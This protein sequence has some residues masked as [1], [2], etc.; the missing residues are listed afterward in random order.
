M[1]THSLKTNTEHAPRASLRRTLLAAAMLASSTALI[2]AIATTA[3]CAANLCERK[4]TFFERRC[5]GTDLTYSPD[6]LCE[7]NLENCNEGQLRAFEG[8]VRCLEAA[9][10]CS[11]EIVSQC[12]AQHAPG[13]NLQCAPHS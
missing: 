13:V 12:A 9:N 5:A 7:P 4:N 2:A 6:P 10:V 8:Y 11:M 1:E 3:G